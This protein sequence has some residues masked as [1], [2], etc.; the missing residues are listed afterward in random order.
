MKQINSKQLIILIATVTLVFILMQ[1][2]ILPVIDQKE[3]L[4][5]KINQNQARLEEILDLEAE[6]IA[7]RN[8]SSKSFKNSKRG[9]DFT[10]F[11]F[12]EN[13]ASR[14]G[15]KDKIEF[16]RPSTRQISDST[17]ERIVEMRLNELYLTEIIPYLYS[18]EN[19]SENV[20]V[21]RMTIRKNNQQD[22]PLNVD[23]V[24]SIIL[25]SAS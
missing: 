7:V 12:L 10:L 15:L 11:A 14:Q 2:I 22:A 25:S 5:K 21:K 8:T 23:L 4:S 3:Q 6:L 9:K 18:V 20:Y 13:L 1:W 16:M 17:R 19:A 24:F